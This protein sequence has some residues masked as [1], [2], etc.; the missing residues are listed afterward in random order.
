MEIRKVQI[1]GGSSFVITLPKD[2]ANSMNIKKN[3]PLAIIPKPDGSLIITP[4]TSYEKTQRIKE[5]DI[6][7][8]DNDAL[9]F[10]LLIGAYI[11]GHSVIVVRSKKRIP[12]FVRECVRRFTQTSIGV[13]IIEETIGSITLKD[14]LDPSE[15]PFKKT[16]ERMRILVSNM[17]NDALSALVNK[18]RMLAEDVIFRDK[19]VDRLQWL[20]SRQFNMALRDVMLAKKMGVSTPEA[21]SYFMISRIM[22][23]M[24]DH[25]VRI[26]KNAIIILDNDI[27]GEIISSIV[28]AGKKSNEI[29]NMSAESWS[30]K[31]I[32]IASRNVDIIRELVP[33]CKDINRKAFDQESEVALTIGY[34]ADSIRRTGE[35]ATDISEMVINSLME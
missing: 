18:D 27:N 8:V 3:D 25:A 32:K 28:L 24:A 34:I 20:I 2:W 16:I 31:D 22:E 23:R 14:L 12:P 7:D 30:K 6:D 5:L 29:F 13:E 4:Q 19:D 26:A 10:R 17:H 15:M 33:L 1:T 35:Y 9:L 21:T 11:V